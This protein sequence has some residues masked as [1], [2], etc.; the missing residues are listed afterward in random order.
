MS[1][2]NTLILNWNQNITSENF[3]NNK[4]RRFTKHKYKVNLISTAIS[5]F[6]NENYVKFR[7]DVD[8]RKT[9]LYI[10]F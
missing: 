4:T 9:Y 3:E 8:W 6:K 2:T 1:K 10:N 5:K 7:L